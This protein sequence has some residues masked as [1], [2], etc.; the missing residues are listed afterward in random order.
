[1]DEDITTSDNEVPGMK[2]SPSQP[3]TDPVVRPDEAKESLSP[4]AAAAA[5]VNEAVE[6]TSAAVHAA[7]DVTFKAETLPDLRPQNESQTVEEPTPD[8]TSNQDEQMTAP[9]VA[10][11]HRTPCVTDTMPTQDDSSQTAPSTAA[12]EEAKKINGRPKPCD[13]CKMRKIRVGTM[14]HD[15]IL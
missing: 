15:R 2:R 13:A 10:E 11:R 14:L 9:D 5:T 7:D 8:K 3:P 4:P 6:E 1:M 12:G